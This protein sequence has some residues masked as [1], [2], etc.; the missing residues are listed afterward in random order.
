MTRSS[1]PR[2]RVILVFPVKLIVKITQS[3]SVLHNYDPRTGTSSQT[4][5]PG[6]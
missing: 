1:V 3:N 6:V 2:V 4:I 5:S